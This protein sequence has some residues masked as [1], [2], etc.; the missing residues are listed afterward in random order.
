MQNEYN[1]DQ[2][3]KLACCEDSDEI[4]LADYCLVLWKRK[5]FIL[6]A[7]ILPTICV[8]AALFFAPKKYTVTYVYD[9]SGL[10]LTEKNY[11]LLLN[12]FYSEDNLARLG[13]ELQKNGLEKYA[14]KLENNFQLENFIKFEAVPAFFDVSRLKII[15]AEQLN[16][17]KAMRASLLN[18]TIT[19]DSAKMLSPISSIICNNIKDVIPLYMTKEQLS[20]LIE[21]YNN[22]LADIEKNRFSLGL[23]LKNTNEILT[24]L[25]KVNT[26]SLEANRESVVLQFNVGEQNQYLPLSYQIQAAESKRIDIEET[27]KTTEEKYNYYKDLVDLNNK[28]LA[29]LDTKLHSDYNTEQFKVFLLGLLDTTEKPQLKDYLSSYIRTIENKVAANKPVIENP[30]IISVSRGTTKKMGAI[31]AGCLILSVF[32]AFLMESFEKNKT[33]PF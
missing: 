23:S 13:R 18:T 2:N 20:T 31:F 5:I 33:R 30:N 3:N 14:Q 8:A 1:S 28:V 27:I 29:E 4:N 15:D 16:T 10:E 7:T 22:I 21:E 9:A 19:G 17:I 26:G 25:K 24:G 32:A 12:R 11:T 6:L